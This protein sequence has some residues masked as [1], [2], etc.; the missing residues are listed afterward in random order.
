MPAKLFESDFPI[1]FNADGPLWMVS[2]IFG[3]Y[4]VFPLIARQYHRH[5]VAGLAVAAAITLAWRE[6]AI[7]A[8]SFF[9]SINGAAPDLV[10]ELIVTDQLPGWA[11]SFALGMTGAWA[12]HGLQQ[13]GTADSVRR[14]ASLL[15]AGGLIACCI[16]GYFYGQE[17]LEVDSAI[18]GSHAR[19]EPVLGLAYSAS[20]VVL[21]AGIALGPLW[22]QAPFVNR[23]VRRGAELS[24]AFYL[25]HL[26]VAVYVCRIWLDLPTDGAPLTVLAWFAVVVSISL[27]YALASRRLVERPVR[28]WAIRVTTPSPPPVPGLAAARS[29][30]PP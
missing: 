29:P 26:A 3:F 9:D 5:P 21:M 4:L 18:A 2:V 20:R 25:I 27:L 30:S 8:T 10:T 16:C 7:H 19:A 11:F 13:R 17:A 24:Y 23:P 15:A 14:P 22:M 28:K 1:G 12:Y 6:A